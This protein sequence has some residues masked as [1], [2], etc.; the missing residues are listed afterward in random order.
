MRMLIDWHSF[1]YMATVPWPE[2]GEPQIDWEI[3]VQAIE[4]WLKNH[5]GS[6]LKNWA[7]TDSHFCYN[8]GVAFRWD[9]DRT[10]F[11]LTWA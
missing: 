9:Q 7:W 10:L 1:E 11:V 8:I 4:F 5:V 6:Y 3:G 2:T